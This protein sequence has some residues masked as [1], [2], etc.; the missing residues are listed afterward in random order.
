LQTPTPSLTDEVEGLQGVHIH[1]LSGE[2]NLPHKPSLGCAE[3]STHDKRNTA[4]ERNRVMREMIGDSGTRLERGEREGKRRDGGRERERKKEREKESRAVTHNPYLVWRARESVDSC[5]RS[6]SKVIRGHRAVSRVPATAE[7][8][9][10]EA[11]WNISEVGSEGTRCSKVAVT[12]TVMLA[13][14]M[15]VTTTKPDQFTKRQYRTG[16]QRNR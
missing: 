1:A 3:R 12:V 15:I 6:E 14:R 9:N 7:K 4:L 11:E 2:Q 5:S 13:W 10:K 16:N 8:I